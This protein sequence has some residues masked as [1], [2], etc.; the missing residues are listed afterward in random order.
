MYQIINSNDL[1]GE[2]LYVCAF[3]FIILLFFYESIFL[4]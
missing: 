2:G 1:W 3:F 4:R